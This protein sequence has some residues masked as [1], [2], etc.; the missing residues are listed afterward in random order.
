MKRHPQDDRERQFT[1]VLSIGC[2]IYACATPAMNTVISKPGVSDQ[3]SMTFGIVFLL[4]GWVGTT[5]PVVAWWANIMLFCGW[6]ALI[7]RRWAGAF[8]LGVLSLFLAADTFRLLT[9]PL[10]TIGF[11]SSVDSQATSATQLYPGGYLWFGS[12]AILV[13]GAALGWRRFRPTT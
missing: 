11:R 12:M 10:P 3:S 7:R 13:I 2:Y 5:I 4:I 8:V 6:Y 9:N 1:L